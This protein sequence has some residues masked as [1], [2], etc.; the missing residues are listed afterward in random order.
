MTPLQETPPMSFRLA[1]VA[2][3]FLAS[4]AFPLEPRDVFLVVNK[5]V[6]ASQQVAD[7]YLAKRGVPK[8][9]V[10]VLD[11]PAGEDISRDDFDKKLAA[12]LQQALR[13]RQDKVKVL[14]TVYGVP[15]RVGVRTPSALDKMDLEKLKPD[16]DAANKR[17]A[18]LQ[19]KLKEKQDAAVQKELLDAL[20]QQ[21]E[22]TERQMTLNHQESTAAVDS[23]LMLLWLHPNY[24]V[25][26]W[27][28]N[29][30]H[31]EFPAERRKSLPPILMTCRI[32]GPSPEIA[33]GL[34]DQAIEVEAKGLKGKVYVD[35][36]GI[37]FDV[38]N[39]SENGGY[40]FGGYDESMREMAA[41]LKKG[42]MDVV[43]DDKEPLFPVGSCP[44]CA[45]YCGWYS[46]ATYVD[47][48]TFA[49]GA[50]A[51]HLASAE[52]NSLRDPK[53]NVWCKRLLDKGVAATLGPVAEPYTV[54]F[55]KPAEFFGLLAT[56]QYTLVESYAQTAYFASWMT[57]LVGDPLY[58]PFAK[59]PVAKEADIGPS[60][61]GMKSLFK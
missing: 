32:D 7:H 31:R 46:L 22:L 1:A 57:V 24:P 53:T 28:L 9:N 11:L 19:A 49:R 55:P 16:L 54:G 14:L 43:L 18:D 34:V 56:G 41:L 33:K 17:V 48:C 10:V 30:L 52:A 25:A 20:K 21:A 5:N 40:G 47:C 2:A 39:P 13:S 26:R 37:K 3:L 35:A 59:N 58:K 38:N 61:K 15:L 23:E 51:W 42:G 44:D 27:Q 50:I 29:P 60:P 4:P 12:P 8:E 6:P 45:L 36:R